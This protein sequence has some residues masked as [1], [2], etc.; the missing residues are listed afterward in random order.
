MPLCKICGVYASVKDYEPNLSL[1]DLQDKVGLVHPI[2]R[3]DIFAKWFPT[4]ERGFQN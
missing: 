3:I 4:L 1:N 2:V